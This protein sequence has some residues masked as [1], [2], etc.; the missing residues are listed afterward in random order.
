MTSCWSYPFLTKRKTFVTYMRH[1]YDR[2]QITRIPIV[3]SSDSTYEMWLAYL[4]K[5][6]TYI[7]L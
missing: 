5:S 7:Y 2:W 4:Q 6:T 1:M 3:S